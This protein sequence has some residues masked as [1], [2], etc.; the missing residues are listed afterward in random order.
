MSKNILSFLK[1]LSS[2]KEMP[3]VTDESDTGDMAKYAELC[4]YR[5]RAFE[6]ISQ[7]IQCEETGENE[8]LA[9]S[10]YRVRIE[11]KLIG[12]MNNGTIITI[13][14]IQFSTF[15]ILVHGVSRLVF[16]SWNKV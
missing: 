14:P 6:F 3:H 10:L 15:K 16:V 11:L 8:N 9:Q 1:K 2:N 5:R 12:I 7:A 4:D 13:P